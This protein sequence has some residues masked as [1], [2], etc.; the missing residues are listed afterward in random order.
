MDIIH[1]CLVF[2]LA[3]FGFLGIRGVLVCGWGV[4]R[5]ASKGNIR[6]IPVQMNKIK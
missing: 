5:G 1:G 3:V 6:L 4:A 2:A